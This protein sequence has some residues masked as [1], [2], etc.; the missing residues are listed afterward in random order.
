MIVKVLSVREAPSLDLSPQKMKVTSGQR[1]SWPRGQMATSA[2]R[3]VQASLITLAVLG[4]REA[5]KGS[6]SLARTGE[7]H[8]RPLGFSRAC[9]FLYRVTVHLL[10]PI[11]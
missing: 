10:E 2:T 4:E 9:Q 8:R 3:E 5:A 1:D 7:N 11:L 6:F